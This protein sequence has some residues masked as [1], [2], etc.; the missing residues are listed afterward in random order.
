MVLGVPPFSETP[1]YHELIPIPIASSSFPPFPLPPTPY[2]RGGTTFVLTLQSTTMF[3]EKALRMPSEKQVAS[4]YQSWNTNWNLT[5]S[6]IVEFN[7]I[8]RVWHFDLFATL[9]NPNDFWAIAIINNWL[10]VHIK[11]LYPL[12]PNIEPTRLSPPQNAFSSD[13]TNVPWRLQST[14]GFSVGMHSSCQFMLVV[15]HHRNQHQRH[16]HHH[17]HHHYP[18]HLHHR[19]DSHPLVSLAAKALVHFSRILEMRE[20]PGK[21]RHDVFNVSDKASLLPSSSS[22]SRKQFAL[23]SAMQQFCNS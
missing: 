10:Q 19:V 23:I 22:W 21:P 12:E 1:I 6:R 11:H 18:H 13:A 15:V 2:Y 14:A 8:R 16:H 5:T 20:C 4:M 3:F 9:Y 17:D 7:V